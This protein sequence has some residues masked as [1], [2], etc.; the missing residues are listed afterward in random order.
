MI[1]NGEKQALGR[2][3]PYPPVEQDFPDESRVE[4]VLTAEEVVELTPEVAVLP[5]YRKVATPD[6]IKQDA[7]DRAIQDA[8]QSVRLLESSLA[9]FDVVDPA[10]AREETDRLVDVMSDYV[11]R[12][13]GRVR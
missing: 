6:S 3:V 5:T 7:V 1:E 8:R 11:S 4:R 12:V 10:A 9:W 13:E 2:D